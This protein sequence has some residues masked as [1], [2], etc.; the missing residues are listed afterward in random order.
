VPTCCPSE[1]DALKNYRN[2]G[3]RWYLRAAIRH[4]KNVEKLG[5]RPASGSTVSLKQILPT[6]NPFHVIA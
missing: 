6:F 2:G 5:N 1:R 4:A 3:A